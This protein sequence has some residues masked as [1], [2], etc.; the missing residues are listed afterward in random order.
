MLFDLVQR[1][2]PTLEALTSPAPLRVLRRVAAHKNHAARFRK[3]L[4]YRHREAKTPAEKG[5]PPSL[6]GAKRASPLMGQQAG[7]SSCIE[8][9][10]LPRQT[11]PS[12]GDPI[13]DCDSRNPF[14]T[15]NTR[16]WQETRENNPLANITN[17]TRK[18]NKKQTKTNSK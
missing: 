6:H 17:Q 18:K 5:Q 3:S 4:T 2:H 7:C 13:S 10:V 1:V 14:I 15:L 12:F 9:R 16:S 8:S 11:D